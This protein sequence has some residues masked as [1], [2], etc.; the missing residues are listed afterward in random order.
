MRSDSHFFF[1][2]YFLKFKSLFSEVFE[3][4]AARAQAAALRQQPKRLSPDLS[5]F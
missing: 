2:I 1:S 4:D 3:I 5:Q